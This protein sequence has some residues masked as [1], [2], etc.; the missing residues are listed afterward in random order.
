MAEEH[1]SRVST[2]LELRISQAELAGFLSVSRLV[3]N[4][5]LQVWQRKKW[6]EVGSGESW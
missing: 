1:G 4:Q 5:Q 3:V 6:V 2:G